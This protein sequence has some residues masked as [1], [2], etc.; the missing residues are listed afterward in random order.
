MAAPPGT[1]VEGER[2]TWRPATAEKLGSLLGRLH[3]LAPPTGVANSWY[4]PPARAAAEATARLEQFPHLR[5]ALEGVHHVEHCPV[6]LIHADVWRGNVIESPDGAVTLI[7]W[8]YSG[9]GHSILDLADAAAD[10]AQRPLLLTLIDS[11]EA[12]RQLAPAERAA[13]VPAMQIAI[14]LRV[15]KKVEAARWDSIPR[16]I[17]RFERAPLFGL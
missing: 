15:A 12:I 9:L 4:H 17:E 11:Y 14:A 13:F 16:E 5:N 7:D 2:C 10:C 3:T 8:E 6:S 1:F